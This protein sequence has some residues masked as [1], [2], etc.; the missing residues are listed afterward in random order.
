[1]KVDPFARIPTPPCADLLGWRLLDHDAARGWVRVGFEGRASFLNPA[2][3]V[4]G[5]FLAAMLDD[6]MGPAVWVKSG[7]ALYS[8]TIDMHVRYLAPARAGAFTAEAEVVQLG[9]SIAFIEGRLFDAEGIEVARASASAR[10]VPV[11]RALAQER[12]SA[13][14]GAK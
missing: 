9:K 12:S 5:G 7:G 10:L 13:A 14:F 1:M 6:A 4:Q 2:G 11:A 3:F 8:P